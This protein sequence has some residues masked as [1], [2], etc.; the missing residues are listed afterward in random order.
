[1]AGAFDSLPA[2]MKE[3]M[4]KDPTLDVD[5]PPEE[6]NGSIPGPFERYGEPL[7]E[8]NWVPLYRKPL[9]TPTRKLRIACIGAGISAMNLAHKIY[10]ER[11]EELEG[12]E[13]VIYEGREDIGGTVSV[14]IV[15][16]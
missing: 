9:W 11:R 6:A 14:M 13:F 15:I 10:H 12:V 16:E 8:K 1:M 2:S 5:V 7:P 3:M 4:D